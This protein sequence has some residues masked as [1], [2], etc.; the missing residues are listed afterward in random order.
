MN[1]SS[2]DAAASISREAILLDY[3][4]LTRR[5]GGRAMVEGRDDCVSFNVEG[6][7]RGRHLDRR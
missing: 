2:P 5:D 7:K 3:K 4:L 1:S 6:G